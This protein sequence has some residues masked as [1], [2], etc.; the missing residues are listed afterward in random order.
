LAPA[1][2]DADRRVIAQHYLRTWFLVDVLATLPLELVDQ[3]ITQSEASSS[4]SSQ[5]RLHM[6]AFLK[7]RRHVVVHKAHQHSPPSTYF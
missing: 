3:M 1:I 5:Q 7:A 6:F 2:G 4:S